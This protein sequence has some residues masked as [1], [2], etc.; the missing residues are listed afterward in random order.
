[1][2]KITK[3]CQKFNVNIDYSLIFNLCK[4]VNK[5]RNLS[6]RE[7]IKYEFPPVQFL[8]ERDVSL[9]TEHITHNTSY[10]ELTSIPSVTILDFAIK[11]IHRF[12]TLYS[13]VIE[14]NWFSCTKFEC[15]WS[16]LF[17]ETV[18]NK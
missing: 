11:L 16:M 15:L 3:Y 13:F 2:N 7:V 6:R 4:D 18:A 5:S 12:I 9:S 10:S 14:N 17:L 1:M 8:E